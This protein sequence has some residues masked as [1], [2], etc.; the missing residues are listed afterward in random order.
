M[1][2]T[3]A[4]NK[5]GVLLV[6]LGTPSEPTVKGVRAFLKEFLSDPR[7]V[8]LPRW[9]WKPILHGVILNIRPPKVAKAYQSVWADEGS[10]LMVYSKLQAKALQQ[11]LNEAMGH[12][13]PLQLAMTY[14]DP[15]IADG[16]SKLQAQGVEKIITLP[17]YPQYSCTTTASVVDNLANSIKKLRNIPEYCFVKE[18]YQHPFYIEALAASVRAH[19]QQHGQAQKLV[20][21]FH[22]I[23]QRFVD[24]GDPYQAQCQKTAELLAEHLGLNAQQWQVCYQSRF[25]REPWLQPYLDEYL[26]TLPSQGCTS[27][28]VI[29]PAFA[30]DCLETLEE[31]A[32]E[33][34]QLFIENGGNDYRYISCLNDDPK[35]IDLMV[36]LIKSKWGK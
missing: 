17:L 6:N 10:P 14:G 9:L 3:Q 12:E 13:V 22:G 21:S 30:S 28:D 20:M 33:N 31:I 34:K 2:P 36:E 26:T 5:T 29:C 23:P 1:S 25:G 19:W 35:H 8:D 27:I 32:I 24:E 11:S 18:Y 4:A 15:A 16:I 7:V